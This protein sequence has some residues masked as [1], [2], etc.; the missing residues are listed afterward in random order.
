METELVSLLPA[1]Q[2][3]PTSAGEE[4]AGGLTDLTSAQQ[5]YIQEKKG[6]KKK[7]QAAFKRREWLQLSLLEPPA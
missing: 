6:K 4:P 2:V 1:C 7:K 5:W 3:K